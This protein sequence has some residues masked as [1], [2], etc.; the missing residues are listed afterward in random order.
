MS[1]PP[2]TDNRDPSQAQP[3]RTIAIAGTLF[4]IIAGGSTARLIT[5]VLWTDQSLAYVL[6][7]VAAWVALL[8]YTSYVSYGMGHQDAT[9]E[10]HDMVGGS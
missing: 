8:V 3:E 7:D 10:P 4:A 1:A 6:V 5:E 9:Q 2:T